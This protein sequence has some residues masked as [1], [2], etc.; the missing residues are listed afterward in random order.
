MKLMLV[1][2]FVVLAILTESPGESV[3][4]DIID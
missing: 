2:I 1:A 4:S 3:G